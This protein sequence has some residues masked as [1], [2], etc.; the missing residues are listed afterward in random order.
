MAPGQLSGSHPP[1]HWAQAGASWDREHGPQG[2]L[3]PSGKWVS[4]LP[5]PRPECETQSLGPR[6]RAKAVS[7]GPWAWGSNK[8][9]RDG[10]WGTWNL[11]GALGLRGCRGKGPAGALSQCTISAF[12]D[13]PIQTSLYSSEHCPVSASPGLLLL[14]PY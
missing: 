11:L 3:Q 8:R 10:A 4:P 5:P 2:H 7:G 12:P 1:A 14:P 13:S 6:T 9:T